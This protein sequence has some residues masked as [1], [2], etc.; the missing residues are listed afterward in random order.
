MSGKN[1]GKPPATDEMPALLATPGK[2]G[3]YEVR[4]WTVKR[5]A[6]VY[7][8]V[9][10]L[11]ELLVAKGLTL[12]N[13]EVFI[14]GNLLDCL[15]EILPEVAPLLAVTLDIPLEEAGDLDIATATA[16]VLVIFSQNLAPLKNFSSLV[17]GKLTGAGNSTPSP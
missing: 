3:K 17:P 2:V 16:L 5:F 11:I 9:R 1:P 4:P 7:P 10:R 12:E 14:A 8:V 15:P 6:G 13:I